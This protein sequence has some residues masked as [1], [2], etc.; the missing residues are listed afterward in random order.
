[1]VAWK[2]PGADRATHKAT[3]IDKRAATKDSIIRF[4]GAHN[5][6]KTKEVVAVVRIAAVAVRASAVVI[7]VGKRAA[8]NHSFVFT[9]HF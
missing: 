9:N 3:A 6:T 7:T 1:M 8:A 2:V 5:N 4:S